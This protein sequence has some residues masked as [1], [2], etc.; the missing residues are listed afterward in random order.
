MKNNLYMWTNLILGAHFLLFKK[1][2]INKLLPKMP[3]LTKIVST[4]N[5]G[6]FFSSV[7]LLY[8]F[9]KWFHTSL[10]PLLTQQFP[11]SI[12]HF[13]WW[14]LFFRVWAFQPNST[15]FPT[16]SNSSILSNKIFQ[17]CFEEFSFWR[18]TLTDCKCITTDKMASYPN[19]SRKGIDSVAS[20]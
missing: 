17:N 12:H 2:F 13:T 18:C 11:L 8:V 20:L 19:V 9:S 4:K 1:L 6:I 10:W 5:L 16:S 7:F 15:K 14:L 3:I